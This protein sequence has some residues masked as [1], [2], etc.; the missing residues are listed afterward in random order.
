MENGLFGGVS[1]YIRR[2]LDFDM[3]AQRGD[4]PE[5]LLETGC[6]NVLRFH[7]FILVNAYFP[8]ANAGHEEFIKIRQ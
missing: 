1:T 8:Y 3:E 7:Q 6:I 2:G 5:W 4:I